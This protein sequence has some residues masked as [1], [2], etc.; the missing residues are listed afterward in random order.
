MTLPP[1]S[2]RKKRS[3]PAAWS[4]LA[5]CT[6]SWFM[7]VFIRS[8]A[9]RVSKA[10]LRGAISALT[11]FLGTE[12]APALPESEKSVKRTVTFSEGVY[13]KRRRWKRSEFSKARP[14]WGTRNDPWPWR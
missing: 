7:M 8:F 3:P 11:E 2:A 1:K 4:M 14:T 12:V 13:S 10:K 5:T 9:A 6:S